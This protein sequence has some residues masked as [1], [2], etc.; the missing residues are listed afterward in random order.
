MAL[1]L[2]Q[3]NT[4]FHG[5]LEQL[6]RLVS[7]E[8]LLL[9]RDYVRGKL[10]KCPYSDVVM[11][12]RKVARYH[13]LPRDIGTLTKISWALR[14]LEKLGYLKLVSSNPAHFQA[15]EAGR[16]WA[17]I[18]RYPSCS[19]DSGLC[20]LYGFCPIHKLLGVGRQ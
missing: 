2:T 11:T 18:C 9:V 4:V 17:L 12:A 20:G 8:F 3:T 16:Y 14:Y 7:T 1:T 5:S 15:L 13:G 19:N 6:G 10:R